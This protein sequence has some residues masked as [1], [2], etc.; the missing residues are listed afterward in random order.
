MDPTSLATDM[1]E[2]EKKY[3]LSEE[4]RAATIVS[5]G[6]IGA[7]FLGEDS[8]ENIIYG[9][10]ALGQGGAIVRI[11]KTQDRAVLTFKRRVEGQADVKQ[12][13]EY[14]TEVSDAEAVAK[15]LTEL[16]LTPNLVYEKRRRT[17]RFREVE[18]VVDELPFGLYMEIEGSITG[19]KEAEML[20]GIQDL[21]TE[22]GTYPQLTA[23]LGKRKGEMFEA[24]FG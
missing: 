5:L 9:G 21:D 20:L 2:I 3:R 4:S 7:V 12:Q 14:E 22:H 15:I 8:E 6:E 11:R 23:R 1:L 13:L 17:W 16:G 19:I 18:V 10:D 24:R